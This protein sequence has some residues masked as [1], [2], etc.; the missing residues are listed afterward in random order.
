MI[1]RH[2]LRRRRRRGLIYCPATQLTRTRTAL[3]ALG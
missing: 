2:R 1:R 3:V